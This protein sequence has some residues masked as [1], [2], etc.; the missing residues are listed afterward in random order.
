MAAGASSLDWAAPQPSYRFPVASRPQFG[1]AT[2]SS[3]PAS[4][5]IFRNDHLRTGTVGGKAQ[6]RMRDQRG[7]IVATANPALIAKKPSA[8]TKA[9]GRRRRKITA[10][11]AIAAAN[12][13]AHQAG[14][15]SAEK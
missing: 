11:A 2:S 1:E 3:N 7:L 15:W 14:S 5:G 10:I 9:S 13:A 6:N 4:T 12:T 8:R